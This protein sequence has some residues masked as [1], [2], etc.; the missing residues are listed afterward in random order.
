MEPNRNAHLLL[1]PCGIR[2][3]GLPIAAMPNGD[4]VLS[5]GCVVAEDGDVLLR[6]SLTYELTE[7]LPK[8]LLLGGHLLVERLSVLRGRT[9]R[10]L[11]LSRTDGPPEVWLYLESEGVWAVAAASNRS[12]MSR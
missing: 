11:L 12:G 9:R 2:R 8:I 4:L 1:M 6:S 3:P 7:P 10:A 5:P